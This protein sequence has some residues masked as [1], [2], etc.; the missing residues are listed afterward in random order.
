M[1]HASMNVPYRICDGTS[2]RQPFCSVALQ[3]NDMMTFFSIF[4]VFTSAY[5]V[6]SFSLLK[7]GQPTFD[8][9]I[10]RK[11]FHAAYW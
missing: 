8:F 3:L 9:A 6:A 7:S 4:F 1:F 5:G 2:G 11:I 10:F